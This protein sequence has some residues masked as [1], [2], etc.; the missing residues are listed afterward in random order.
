VPHTLAP[1]LMFLTAAEIP[2]STTPSTFTTTFPYGLTG[3]GTTDNFFT[4]ALDLEA[5]LLLRGSGDFMEAA[6]MDAQARLGLGEGGALCAREAHALE[7]DVK[8]HLLQASRSCSK[9]LDSD[10]VY[11]REDIKSAL[12][13]VLGESGRMALLLGGKSVGKSLL[14]AEL[15]DARRVIVGLDGKER[16]ILYVDARSCGGDLTAGLV[17]AITRTSLGAA[18]P[19]SNAVKN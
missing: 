8:T 11:D 3:T 15:A 16:A 9:F 4:T 6:R 2:S 14:L 19:C 18:N 12:Q 7:E 5:P 13:R 1:V 17:A 10:T